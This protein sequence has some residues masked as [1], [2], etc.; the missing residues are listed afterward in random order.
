MT[1]EGE[2]RTA[3]SASAIVCSSTTR[4]VE[5]SRSNESVFFSNY[6]YPYY[7]DYESFSKKNAFDFVFRQAERNAGTDWIL[8]LAYCRYLGSG[9]EKW[10]SQKVEDFLKE[11]GLS[12]TIDLLPFDEDDKDP[13]SEKYKE[14][15]A[16]YIEEKNAEIAGLEK[17]SNENDL[18]A[19]FKLALE[20]NSE[21]DTESRKKAHELFSKTV[22]I[23]DHVEYEYVSEENSWKRLE[24]AGEALY[25]LG[26]Y[27][28]E[29]LLEKANEEK[30]KEFFMQ[31]MF[32]GND[33]SAYEIGQLS[34]RG[35]WSDED[36]EYKQDIDFA[37]G[38]YK[39]AAKKGNWLSESE[40]ENYNIKIEEDSDSQESDSD[41]DFDEEEMS[42]VFVKYSEY[43]KNGNVTYTENPYLLAKLKDCRKPFCSL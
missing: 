10:E 6:D 17:R 1:A 27:S 14:E 30:A 35:Y 9:C 39:T 37:I 23:F 15:R 32:Y 31:G 40:L 16:N 22:Y 26:K 29:G 25:F 11:N 18:I 2:S 8:A 28:Q 38:C 42:E 21:S 20:Y 5:K 36:K 7:E 12:D 43:D 33:S 41:D 3:S 4:G 34:E 19:T 13:N 24:C